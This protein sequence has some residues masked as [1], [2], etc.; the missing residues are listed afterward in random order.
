MLTWHD[1]LVSKYRVRHSGPSALLYRPIPP[2]KARQVW[3]QSTT[4]IQGQ[5]RKLEAFHATVKALL[6]ASK[7][8]MI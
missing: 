6:L 4:S 3:Q 1:G 8:R 2:L 7:S 5:V